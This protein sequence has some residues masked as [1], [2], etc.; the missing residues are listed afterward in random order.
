MGIGYKIR[1]K[2]IFL[3]R[4]GVLN[5]AIIRNKKPFPPTSI[6]ELEILPG[7]YEGVQLLK[8]A[9]FKLIII[10][11]Q[12]DVSRGTLKIEELNKINKS[13]IDQLEIDEVIC[14][15]HD[16]IDNCDC[17]K[18][19]AGLFYSAAQDLNINLEMS[20]MVGD[21]WRDIHA[22]QVAGCECFYI[23]YKYEEFQPKSPF[24]KV[25][26]LL[27]AANLIFERN[28]QNGHK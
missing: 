18:P 19:R 26:S 23:D 2:A 6:S 17:R 3:D 21:R 25:S 12:P 24:T 15:L 28:R 20:Y 16:D 7:V 9:G 8:H 1:N 13:I 11:N 14:C 22:G 4:D 27:E 10:S 5:K